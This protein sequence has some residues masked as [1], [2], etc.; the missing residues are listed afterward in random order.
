MTYQDFYY[1]SGTIC[2][3]IVSILA[4]ML[5]YSRIYMPRVRRRRNR[6]I[7]RLED[8]LDNF[9]NYA[10]KNFAQ[11]GLYTAADFN[12]SIGILEGKSISVINNGTTAIL[13]NGGRIDPAGTY[14]ITPQP[15]EIFT[16][17]LEIKSMEIEID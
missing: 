17:N 12:V 5:A 3:M 15:G 16:G 10:L 4:L 8:D 11:K 14:S 13:L 6:I 9:K 7:E 1:L 2:A